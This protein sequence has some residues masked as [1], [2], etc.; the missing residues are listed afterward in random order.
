[1]ASVNQIKRDIETYRAV[2]QDERRALAVAVPLASNQH[3]CMDRVERVGWIVAALQA[4][5]ALLEEPQ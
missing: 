4:Y 2:L 5:L 1:M 3:A